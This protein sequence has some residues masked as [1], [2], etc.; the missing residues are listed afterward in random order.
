MSGSNPFATRFTRPG[1]LP[2]FDAA[3]R[4]I[5]LDALLARADRM[6]RAVIVG[7]HGS[8]KSTLLAHVVARLRERGDAVHAVRLRSIRDLPGLALAIASAGPRAT[9]AVDSWE[10][11][12]TAGGA[13]VRA[14]AWCRGCRCIATSHE[15]AGLPVLADCRPTPAVLESIVAHLPDAGAWYGPIIAKQDLRDAF[16][17]HGGDIREA[18]FDLYDRF[19]ARQRAVRTVRI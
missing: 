14:A 4:R 12:G 6:R 18:L 10:R 1:Q 5:D 19:D 7:P 17:R 15:A 8:G 9:V 2:P 3:G 11:L 13:I 16:E